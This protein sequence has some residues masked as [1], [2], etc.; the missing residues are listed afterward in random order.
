MLLLPAQNRKAARSLHLPKDRALASAVNKPS[1]CNTICT[2][3]LQG[4][5][6]ALPSSPNATLKGT[7]ELAT[8]PLS[9]RPHPYFLSFVMRAQ[10]QLD[11]FSKVKY[12]SSG[13]F[14]G[15]LGPAS[16]EAALRRGMPDYKPSWQELSG[17]QR[18]WHWGQ[19]GRR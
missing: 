12:R 19:K 18:R 3:Y 10:P 16:G 5:A 11:P 1:L 15:P 14:T 17:A 4:Q 9:L 7:Q 8:L 6:R 2:A 13:P